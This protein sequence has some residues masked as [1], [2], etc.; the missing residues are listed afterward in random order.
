MLTSQTTLYALPRW[1]PRLR[2]LGVS[3]L[4][5]VDDAVVEALVEGLEALQV[6]DLSRCNNVRKKAN[7]QRRMVEAAGWWKVKDEVW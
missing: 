4:H 2:V 6:L 5:S 3:G 1:F 7:Q